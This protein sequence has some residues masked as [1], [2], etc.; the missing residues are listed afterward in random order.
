VGKRRGGKLRRSWT[1]KGLRE[2]LK[3]NS[4]RNSDLSSQPDFVSSRDESTETIGAFIWLEDMI[5]T[6][7]SLRPANGVDLPDQLHLET[8]TLREIENVNENSL[9]DLLK[10]SSIS[11]GECWFPPT[12]GNGLD[13]KKRSFWSQRGTEWRSLIEKITS[14]NFQTGPGRIKMKHK[15]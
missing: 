3:E 10:P 6:Y 1:S 2:S 5:E 13:L 8:L 11:K 14:R 7:T 9:V 12:S 15:Y 4:T